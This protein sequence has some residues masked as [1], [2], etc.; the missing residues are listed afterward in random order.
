MEQKRT[1]NNSAVHYVSN[2]SLIEELELCHKNG[3]PS[4]KLHLYFYEI[5]TKIA[6]R[7]NFKNYTFVEDMIHNA[8]F[9][10]ITKWDKFDLSKQNAFAYFTTVAFN[11]FIQLINKENMQQEIKNDVLRNI[12]DDL[13]Q[14][15]GIRYDNYLNEEGEN[16]DD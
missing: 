8:Y 1:A 10:M 13:E 9:R 15:F 12:S 16:F 7:H 4:E 14:E 5:A 6:K 11:E 3:A 2:K